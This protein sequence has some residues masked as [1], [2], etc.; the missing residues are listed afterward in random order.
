VVGNGPEIK[1]GLDELKMGPVHNIDISIP[2]APGSAGASGG[3]ETK[4]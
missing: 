4:E 3:A 1:P 2:G